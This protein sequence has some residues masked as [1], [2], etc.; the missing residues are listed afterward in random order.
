MQIDAIS[1][2][3]LQPKGLK[4]REF[5]TKDTLAEKHRNIILS[6]RC[7]EVYHHLNGRSLITH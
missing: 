7:F 6:K 1:M 5:N 2:L 3:D 4:T